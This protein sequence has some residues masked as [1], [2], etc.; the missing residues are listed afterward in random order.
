MCFAHVASAV[1]SHVPL[2]LVRGQPARVTILSCI[3][4]FSARVLVAPRLFLYYFESRF[5]RNVPQKLHI[6]GRFLRIIHEIH[7][8]FL[9]IVHKTHG[10][11]LKSSASLQAPLEHTSV[12]FPNMLL[13]PLFQRKCLS[14][15]MKEIQYPFSSFSKTPH[16]T[17]NFMLW[18][19]S[20]KHI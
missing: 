10:Q 9:R 12:V 14:T 6:Y 17:F 16:K 4:C 1:S 3:L 13:H 19:C 2:R 11:F 18:I 20:Q 8:R 5:L 7:G 15:R